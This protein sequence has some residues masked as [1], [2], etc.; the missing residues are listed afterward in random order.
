MDTTNRETYD[1]RH[2]KSKEQTEAEVGRARLREDFKQ[3]MKGIPPG[4]PS[5]RP[6]PM[7][8]KPA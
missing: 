3:R 7:M 2:E 8:R 5:R 6:K 4:T 1:G